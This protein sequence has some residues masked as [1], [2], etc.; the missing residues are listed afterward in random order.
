MI[1]GLNRMRGSLKLG[2]FIGGRTGQW[3]GVPLQREVSDVEKVPPPQVPIGVKNNDEVSVTHF[4]SFVPGWSG[5]GRRECQGPG[6]VAGVLHLCRRNARV[7]PASKNKDE[8]KND[9]GSDDASSAEDDRRSKYCRCQMHPSQNYAKIID[10]WEK[11]IHYKWHSMNWMDRIWCTESLMGG[12]DAGIKKRHVTI[13][14]RLRY[15]I[16]PQ[17]NITTT[18]IH[19]S[20]VPLVMI[21]QG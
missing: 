14:Q 17:L 11:N 13:Q 20:S 6:A 8:H 19:R 18:S 2:A 12:L 5:A 15:M 16:L 7:I 4:V 3:S 21:L 1:G 9:F 10:L